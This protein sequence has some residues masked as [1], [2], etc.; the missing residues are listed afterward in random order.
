MPVSPSSSAK[1]SL[2][3]HGGATSSSTY[4]HLSSHI[5]LQ[6]PHLFATQEFPNDPFKVLRR[7]GIGNF[8]EVRI[9]IHVQHNRD[10]YKRQRKSWREGIDSNIRT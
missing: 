3:T 8:G 4:S 6:D 10:V 1:S 5:K 2:R 7:L 9:V